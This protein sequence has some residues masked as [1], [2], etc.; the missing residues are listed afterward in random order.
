MRI[1]HVV[2]FASVDGAFGGPLAVASAQCREL[3]KRGHEVHLVAGWDGRLDLNIPGVSVHPIAAHKLGNGMSTLIAPRLSSTLLSL[4]ADLTHIHLGRD[5]V[6]APVAL[7]LLGAGRPYVAQT[8]GMVASDRRLKSVAFDLFF[9]RR[10]LRGAK[11]V[12]VLGDNERAQ[13]LAVDRSLDNLGHLSNGIGSAQAINDGSARTRVVFLARLHPRKGV[14]AFAEAALI[15]QGAGVA[16]EFA[17]YGPDEG[18]LG[19]LSRFI[20]EHPDASITYEGSVAPGG[21]LDVLRSSGVYVL[22][23]RGEVFPMTVLESL[24]VGTPVVMGEDSEVSSVLE[25]RGA[26]RLTDGSAASIAWELRSLIEDER[27]W[28]G[29]SS[30]GLAAVDDLLSS[31]AVVN[32]LI[33]M[34][35]EM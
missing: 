2:T 6:T 9:T 24:S 22:P 18:D 17:V 13:I 1:A 32:R 34:Y 31:E 26:V 23:S 3:A 15:L 11:R 20:E 27:V 30:A 25:E 12:L 7:A 4:N 33:S 5:L 14:M 8:H 10:I 28:R 29:M 35:E 16:A 21:S 19:R